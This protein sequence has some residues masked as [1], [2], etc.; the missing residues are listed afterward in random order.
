MFECLEAIRLEKIRPDETRNGRFV[1][2]EGLNL[3]Q[4]L[5]AHKFSGPLEQVDTSVDVSKTKEEAE[6]F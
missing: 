1:E 2:P 4:E 6:V 3:E 5:S